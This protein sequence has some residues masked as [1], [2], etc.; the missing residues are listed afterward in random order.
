[1]KSIFLK[2]QSSQTVSSQRYA[3]WPLCHVDVMEKINVMEVLEMSLRNPSCH[4]ELID[5]FQFSPLTLGAENKKL[6]KRITWKSIFGSS[7]NMNML[8]K[9]YFWYLLICVFNWRH[10]IISSNVFFPKISWNGVFDCHEEF[11]GL[12]SIILKWLATVV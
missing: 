10:P 2:L 4:G 8:K 1:M 5:D 9:D 7:Q 3:R 12:W 11:H 6:P